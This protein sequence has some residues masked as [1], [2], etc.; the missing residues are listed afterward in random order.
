MGSILLEIHLGNGN[1]RLAVVD[2]NSNNDPAWFLIKQKQAFKN[3]KRY[4]ENFTKFSK[5]YFEA[6]VI[7][8]RQTRNTITTVS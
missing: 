6:F 2:S 8:L 5:Y 3:R 7:R 1:T 4:F